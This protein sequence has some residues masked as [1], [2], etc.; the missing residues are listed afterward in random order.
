MAPRP[1]LEYPH[2]G[3]FAE[4]RKANRGKSPER[5]SVW[6]GEERK[7]AKRGERRRGENHLKEGVDGEPVGEGAAHR[8][9]RELP[10]RSHDYVRS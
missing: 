7:K 1:G 10:S 3:P 6:I 5:R 9:R 4:R 2:E 8:L